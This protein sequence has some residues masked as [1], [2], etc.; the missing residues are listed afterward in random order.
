MSPGSSVSLPRPHPWLLWWGW[1]LGCSPGC[2]DLGADSCRSRCRRCCWRRPGPSPASGLGRR[3]SSGV[4]P[5]NRSGC[6]LRH[7][8]TYFSLQSGDRI[9]TFKKIQGAEGTH[10]GTVRRPSLGSAHGC[11]SQT[12]RFLNSSC[13]FELDLKGGGGGTH[14][15][16][17]GSCCRFRINT[18]VMQQHESETETER[19]ET[20]NRRRRRHKHHLNDRKYITTITS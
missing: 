17:E 11:L 18:S 2:G 8:G 6:R 7:G 20:R 14:A 16:C 1:S 5:G 4:D 3:R 15:E 12:D 19:H 13:G 9:W 10:V